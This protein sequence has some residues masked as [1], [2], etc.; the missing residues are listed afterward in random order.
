MKTSIITS[1]LA[2]ITALSMTTVAGASLRHG[3][4]GPPPE[5]ANVEG[6]RMALKENSKAGMK[7]PRKNRRRDAKKSELSGNAL[8]PPG[9]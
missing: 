8:P 2:I 4:A 3:T 9:P 5:A 1:F 7:P 6:V